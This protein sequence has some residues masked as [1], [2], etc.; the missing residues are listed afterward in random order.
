MADV[1]WRCN[2]CGAERPP[3]AME[4]ACGKAAECS[5]CA[6]RARVIFC[7]RCGTRRRADEARCAACGPRFLPTVEPLRP[8]GTIREFT[9]APDWL[10]PV[11]PFV[12]QPPLRERDQIDRLVGHFPDYL[13]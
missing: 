6:A 7:T 11:K 5:G 13:L 9:E 12:E 8:N 2:V 10:Y 3:T 4:I 1:V